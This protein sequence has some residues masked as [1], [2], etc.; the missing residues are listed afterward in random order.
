MPVLEQSIA[1]NQATSDE[2]MQTS[3]L[4]FIAPASE[5]LGREINVA[6]LVNGVG[7]DG[8]TLKGIVLEAIRQTFLSAPTSDAFQAISNA[9]TNAN[10]AVRQHRSPPTERPITGCS[11]T[12][13][14]VVGDRLF[15]G[16]IGDN[17]VYLFRDDEIATLAADHSWVQ[18]AKQSWRVKPGEI[19]E[20]S[21]GDLPSQYLGK[22]E[23]ITPRLA[24][25]EFLWP[26]DILLLCTAGLL[27]LRDNEIH[28]IV[29]SS[30]PHQ[31][32]RRLV[33]IAS[34]RG[35]QGDVTSMILQLPQGARADRVMPVPG[36]RM[37]GLSPVTIGLVLANL[38][39]ICLVAGVVLRGSSFLAPAQPI[40]VAKP[41]FVVAPTSTPTPGLDVGAA[42]LTPTVPSSSPAPAPTLLPAATATPSPAPT[43]TPQPPP[44]D[45]LVPPA[46]ALLLPT[47]STVFNGT[48]SDVILE[49]RTVGPMP[50]DVFYV[51]SIKKWVNGKYVGESKN[52]TR[53]NRIRLDS[54][55]Y[56]AF[57]EG[58][59]RFANAAPNLAGAVDQ[60]EWSVALYRLTLIKPDGTLQGVPLAPPTSVRR[61][62]WGPPL[63]TRVYGG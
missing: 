54:S 49:W 18:E 39:L 59:R 5:E 46:P 23:A 50:E 2:P 31:A 9:L 62:S 55:F 16:N 20:H 10:A 21:S 52:W 34:D 45:W 41:A 27:R 30:D 26:G 4:S 24:P 12:L 35:A 13:A 8:D 58:P 22:D 3:G 60:F 32:S 42:E 57:Q 19:Q 43:F 15:V 11:A 56:T 17:R 6:V 61:F 44:A 38:L 25:I 40:E 29:A 7:P 33:Q 1:S 14:L 53:S 36:R 51:V 28:D 48:L 63:P 47:D 37:I